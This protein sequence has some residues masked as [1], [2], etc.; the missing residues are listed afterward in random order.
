MTAHSAWV[1]YER[2]RWHHQPLPKER[3]WVLLLLAAQPEKGWPQGVAAGYMKFG[4][5][6]KDSPYFIIPGIGGKV[7]AWCDCLPDDFRE[8]LYA[9][10]DMLCAVPTT[11]EESDG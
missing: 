10:I 9:T 5:G 6:E 2:E 11:E 7:I 8:N 3:R 4:A 1:P